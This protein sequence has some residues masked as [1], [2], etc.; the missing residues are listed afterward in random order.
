MTK[1]RLRIFWMLLFFSGIPLASFAQDDYTIEIVSGANPITGTGT[2]ISAPDIY[3][4]LPIGFTFE[5]FNQNYDHFYLS[6]NG[7]ITFNDDGDEGCCSSSELPGIN[8]PNNLIAFAWTYLDPNAGQINY[9]TTGSAPNRILVVN[10]NGVNQY[11]WWGGAGNPITVQL[12]LYEGSNTIE[13]HV[14]S[15]PAA[16]YDNRTMGIENVDGTKAYVVDGRNANMN[17]VASDEVVRFLPYVPQPNDAGIVEIAEVSPACGSAPVEVTLQNFG[18]NT[19]STVEIGWSVN[20]VVQNSIM[21]TGSPLV[22]YGVSGTN[23]ALVSLG[24]INVV[25][26]ETYDIQAWTISPNGTTDPNLANDTSQIT[27]Y[28]GL[29]GTYTI[30]QTGGDFG[31]WTEAVDKLSQ[32]GV[33]GPVVFDVLGSFTEQI[34]I[35]EITGASATNTITFQSAS[36][37]AIDAVLSAF[38][39]NFNTNYTL[40]LDGTDHLIVQNLTIK[41]NNSSF[42]RAIWMEG[43]T[44]HNQFIGNII[45][46]QGTNGAVIE[47]SAGNVTT[48]IAEFNTFKS[49]NIKNGSTGIELSG[50]STA[51]DGLGEQNLIEDNVFENQHS[52]GINLFQQSAPLVKGN[53]ITL[54]S[55]SSTNA[56]GIRFFKC[57]GA[58]QIINN[59]ISILNGGYGIIQTENQ[60]SLGAEGRVVNN[61]VLVDGTNQ[62]RGI[63]IS[64]V[65]YVNYYHNTFHVKSTNSNSVAFQLGNLWSVSS[66]NNLDLRNNI[67][68]NTGGGY[69]IHLN[70]SQN[71]ISISDYNVLY[72]TGDFIGYFE[73]PIADLASWQT[74]TQKEA[75][76]L[77]LN[78][79]FI[80]DTDLHPT[81]IALN[82]TGDA[83]GISEDLEGVVRGTPPDIGAYEFDPTG[84]DAK[85]SSLVSPAIPFAHGNQDVKVRLTNNGVTSLS[86]VQ[87][88][89][90]VNDVLQNPFSWS[91]SLSSGQHV[92][93]N[94]GAFS[95]TAGQ[96][97][98]IEVWTSAPNGGT[99]DIAA[100]DQIMEMGLYPM[101]ASGTYT[102]GLGQPYPTFQSAINAMM[103][104]GIEA[105]ITFNVVSGTY[106]EQLIIPEII[107]ANAANSIVFQ[108]QSGDRTDVI[109]QYGGQRSNTNYVVQLDGI[110]GV[111]FKNMTIKTN[112][113]SRGRVI[114]IKNEANHI[115]FENNELIGWAFRHE[116]VKT[117]AD[118]NDNVHF[119][120][121]RIVNGTHGVFISG[122]DNANPST[123]WVVMGNQFENQNSS[124][125]WGDYLANTSISENTF[126]G[127]SS[128]L[129]GIHLQRSASNI[130]I[131]KNIMNFT[132]ASFGINLSIVTDALVSNNMI[133]ISG[134]AQIRGIVVN[135]CN[136]SKIYYNSVRVASSNSFS[137]A[138]RL[139]YSSDVDI[140]NN[141]L[142]NMQVGYAIDVSQL[143]N[144]TL[145]FNNLYST[146]QHIAKLDH[147]DQTT[148]ADWRSNSL[149]D[150]NSLAVNPTFV[151]DTDLHS[152]AIELNGAGTP[153]TDVTDDIDG[154]TR[155]V[156]PDI[157]ADEFVPSGLDVAME[158]LLSPNLPF[159]PGAQ[160][161]KIRFKN[162]GGDAITRVTLNWKVNGAAQSQV[163][164]EDIANPINSGET[165]DLVLGNYNFTDGIAYEVQAWLS[166]PNNSTDLKADNDTLT[167]SSLYTRMAGSYT[168]GGTD[169]NFTHIQAAVDAL[170]IGGV[171]GEVTFNIRSDNYNEQVRI[172][173]IAGA[174]DQNRI[175]FQSETRNRDDVILLYNSIDFSKNYILQLH[176]ADYITFRDVTIK[177]LGSTRSRVL[178]FKD[179]AN[180]NVF[181]NTVL[182]GR[183]NASS[184]DAR[185]VVYSASNLLPDEYNTFSNNKIVN[186]SN[187]IHWQGSSSSSHWET[188]NR[189][190]NNQFENQ[191]QIGIRLQYQDSCEII[192]NTIFST[193]GITAID[194]DNVYNAAKILGNG[195]SITNGTGIDLS[196]CDGTAT[197]PI[198]MANNMISV[199]NVNNQRHGINIS[200]G[201]YVH[202][203]HNTVNVTS[204]SDV[205][206]T[207]LRLDNIGQGYESKNNIFAYTG[208]GAQGYALYERNATNYTSSHNLLYS[209]SYLVDKNGTNYATLGEWQ[210]ASGQEANA[211]SVN[212][213]FVSDTDLHVSEVLL[214][215]TG[216]PL[217]SVTTDFDGETRNTTN[218]DIGADEFTPAAIDVSLELIQ[219]A[220][221]PFGEGA[222]DVVVRMKNA[223]SSDLS[224]V[225]FHWK[226]NDIPQS[227]FTWN[228]TLA[229]GDTSSITIGQVNFALKTAYNIEVWTSEA[230]DANALNDSLKAENLYAGLAGTYQIQGTNPDFDSF[231]EAVNILS[232]G[233]VVGQTTLRVADGIYNEQVS[234]PSLRGSSATN[235]VTF[236]SASG[237]N[238]AVE[239]RIGATSTANYTLQFNGAQY[240]TFKNMS[241]TALSN[242]NGRVIDFS[243]FNSHIQLEGNIL[244]GFNSNNNYSSM[245]VI[246]SSNGNL[247]YIKFI[248]NEIIDGDYGVFFNHNQP[249]L[250]NEFVG[251]TFVGQNYR[252]IE[253]HNQDSIKIERNTISALGS[254]N[255]YYGIY[256]SGSRNA[257][258]IQKN[259]LTLNSNGIGIYMNAINGT[260]SNP[261]TIA[262]NMVSLSGTAGH[263]TYGIRFNNCD[264]LNVYH[265]TAHVYGY[266]AESPNQSAALKFKSIYNS[267]I[268]NN[269]SSNTTGGYAVY[270]SN[271]GSNDVFNH[272]NYYTTGT[273]FVYFNGVEQ[274]NLEAWKLSY[275]LLNANSYNVDPLFISDVDLHI[276][277]VTLQAGGTATPIT[278]DIDDEIRNTTTPSIGA[279]EFP[280]PAIDASISGLFQPVMPFASGSQEVMVTI[281]NQGANVLTSAQLN[282]SVN[283]TTQSAASWT[284]GNVATGD[285]TTVNIGNYTFEPFTVYEVKVWTSN[286]NNGT[287]GN[288]NND[289]LTVSG[290]YVGLSGEYTIGG[291]AP[292]FSTTQEAINALQDGG[293][294]GPVVFKLRDGSYGEQVAIPAILGA[295][296]T[297][298]ISFESESGISANVIWEYSAS[299]TSNYT[300]NL[301]G[302]EYFTFK[303]LTFKALN[304]AQ[305]CV[306]ALTNGASNNRFEG[307]II[308]GIATTGIGKGQ[309]VIYSESE[310][311]S[312]NNNEFK[313]NTIRN[314]SY[315]F[316]YEGQSSSS[317]FD[318]G[319]RL[320]GNVFENQYYRAVYLEHQN[321]PQ[322]IGNHVT[323]NSA[324]W[325]FRGLLL[326]DC[327]NEV[328][329]LANNI[330][331]INGGTAINVKSQGTSGSLSALVAN[332]FTSVGGTATTAI[333]LKLESNS[334][335]EVYYNTSHITNTN[336]SN[337]VAAVYLNN[338][339][340]TKFKNNSMVNSGGGYAM[341]VLNPNT[342][343]LDYNNHY[344]TGVNLGYYNSGNRTDLAAW[345]SVTGQEANSLSVDPNFVSDTDLHFQEIALDG[346]GTPIAAVTDDID[347]EIRN[348][349]HPDMG[350]DEF[351]PSSVDITVSQLVNPSIPFTAQLQE[352]KLVL[353][354]SGLD[355]IT[356]VQLNW[357]VNNQL[358]QA[359]DWVG[360]LPSAGTQEVSLGYFTFLENTEYT[361]K[362][363]AS[364]PNN[365]TG[366]NLEDD[367]LQVSNLQT[368]L[369][370]IYTTGSG[371]NFLDFNDAVNALEARGVS[372]PTTF[373][374]KSA[375]YT[376]QVSIASIAGTS[377][378]NTII[379][380]SE[381]GVNTDVILEY[382]HTN[383]ANYVLRLDGADYL[384]FK[385]M[386]IQASGDYTSST[387]T[388][389]VVDIRN[390]ATNNQFV[391]NRLIG[392]STLNVSRHGSTEVAVVYSPEDATTNA[393]S[394]KN[395]TIQNGAYGIYSAGL[396]VSNPSTG[397][398]IDGNIISGQTK[399][400]VELAHQSGAIVS[401]NEFTSNLG[402]DYIGIKVLG[403][404]GAIQ[405]TRNRIDAHSGYYALYIDG[406]NA[407]AQSR[408]LIANNFIFNDHSSAVEGLRL[409]DMSYTDIY[410]NT[411]RMTGGNSSSRA[412]SIFS[413]NN[414]KFI[415]NIATH[416]ADG[417]SIYASNA[418]NGFIADH[419]LY[420]STSPTRFAYYN[421]S[422]QPQVQDWQSATL[423]DF[424][425]NVVDPV[426]TSASGF[427]VESSL[428]NGKAIPLPA[429][430]EDIDRDL[431]SSTSPD[432]GADEFS[433]STTDAGISAFVSPTIPLNL[434]ANNLKVALTNYG[435][436]TLTKATI[437]WQ[438]D[439]NVQA[440][441]PWE[442]SLSPGASE[443]IT[444]GIYDFTQPYNNYTI[445]AWAT[446]PNDLV[447]QNTVNDTLS[448]IGSLGLAGTYSIGGVNPDFETF[449]GAIDTLTLFGARGPVTFSVADGTYNEQLILD[450]IKGVSEV[451]TVSF[452]SA[453][454]IREQVVLSFDA[455]ST[456]N[457]TVLL[458]G[459]KHITFKQMTIKALNTT[460]AKVISLVSSDQ[461]TFE[462]N[463]IEGQVNNVSI[464]N[465][466]VVSTDNATT[467]LVFKD[468]L[469]KNG[470]YGLYLDGQ[471]SSD[472]KGL[473]IEGNTFERQ[474]QSGIYLNEQESP[475]IRGNHISSPNTVSSYRAIWLEECSE[476][477]EISNNKIDVTTASYG[478]ELKKCN[479]TSSNR[480]LIFNNFIHVGGTN[481]NAYGLWLNDQVHDQYIYH[482]SVYITG[483]HTSSA[484]L[485]M[486]T[487][488]SGITFMNNIF[489]N[490]AGGYALDV[491]NTAAIATANYNNLYSS[492][493]QLVGW[494]ATDYAALS[495]YQT[496]TAKGLN[497]VSINPSFASGSDLHISL[498]ALDGLGTP[499]QE[500][501]LD[502]DGQLRND[503]NPDM[504]ADEFGNGLSTNNIGVL[505]LSNHALGCEFS[506]ET[507]TVS[508]RNYGVDLISD[509]N[510]S[511]AINGGAPI[512]EQVTGFDLAGGTSKAYSFT[513]LADLSA[514]GDYSIQFFTELAGDTDLGND[515]LIAT[516]E[517]TAGP[518]TTLTTDNDD[519]CAR[520]TANLTASGGVSYR[521][522][523]V[524]NTALLG[525]GAEFAV[526]PDS[527]TA[528]Y[529]E[530]ADNN[531][532][533][534]LDTISLTVKNFPQPEI[535]SDNGF[536]LDCNT[537]TINLSSSVEENIIWSTSSALATI[538]V[539][540]PGTYKVTH[541]NQ[542]TGCESE[543]SVE[544]LADPRPNL[545]A[546]KTLICRGETVR[547][548]AENGISYTWE[549]YLATDSAIDVTPAE[550]TI[551]R[552]TISNANG[553]VYKD[554]IRIRIREDVRLTG[555][556][557]DTSICLGEEITLEASGIAE[558]FNWSNNEIGST[559]QVSP[560]QTTTYTVT[561]SDACNV[562]T[563]QG[564][565]TITVL[566]IPQLPVISPESAVIC[567]GN[568]V[569]L[570][571]SMTD[572][573]TWSTDESTASIT[574]N[575]AGIYKVFHEGTNGC[576]AVDS[577][578]VSFPEAPSIELSGY[579]TICNGQSI[580]LGVINGNTYNWTWTSGSS[581]D[582]SITVS[583]T[584]TT[585][586]YVDITNSQGCSY[587]DSM[588]IKVIEPF[589]PSTFGNL[590]PANGEDT[591]TL[592]L[593]FS[594][595]P[596]T[597][598]SHYDLYIW[599]STESEPTSATVTDLTDFTFK[600]HQL[601]YGSSYNW[602]VIAKNSCFETP[603][604][605]Q[606]FSIRQLPD[607][608]PV[609]VKAPLSAFSG[610]KIDVEMEIKNIGLGKTDDQKTWDDY[611]YLSPDKQL[612]E[613]VDFRLGGTNNLTALDANQSYR[614]TIKDLALPKGLDGEYYI[615]TKTNNSNRIAEA[616]L[617]NNVRRSN[618]PLLLNLT[619]P[620]DLK[621]TSIIHLTTAFSG[622]ELQVTWQVM[623]DG[624]GPTDGGNWQDKVYLSKD[625]ILRVGDAIA[626]GVF[627]HDGGKL[628]VGESYEQSQ[629]V[630]IPIEELG[631]YYVHVV[632]D[633]YD[634][635]YEHVYENNNARSGEKI[636]VILAPPADMIVTQVAS[637]QDVV[638]NLDKVAIYWTG[639]NQG[640]ADLRGRYWYDGIYL[641]TATDS[642]FLK[643]VLVRERV[644]PSGTYSKID[645]ITIP[646]DI[647]GVYQLGVHIDHRDLIFESIFTDNN[648]NFSATDLTVQSPDIHVVAV[649]TPSL[650]VDTASTAQTVTV[651][652]TVRNDGAGRLNGATDWTDRIFLS[653]VADPSE[654]FLETLIT[655]GSIRELGSIRYDSTINAG[656]S[657][658]M[659]LELTIPEDMVAGDYHVLVQLDHQ[660]DLYEFPNATNNILSKPLYVKESPV[661][662]LQIAN[663]L[664]TEPTDT[665][666]A[667]RRAVLNYDLSNLGE[668]TAYPSWNNAVYISAEATFNA[669]ARR[670]DLERFNDT[671]LVNETISDSSVM[672]LPTDLEAGSYY[673]FLFV[674]HDSSIYE[675]TGETNNV[676]MVRSFFVKPYPPADLTL[677]AL[678]AVSTANSGAEIQVDWEVKNIGDGSQ[679]EK[680]WYDTL[681][682]STDNVLDRGND[683]VIDYWEQLGPLGRGKSYDR[684]KLVEIPNGISGDYYLIMS[685]SNPKFQNAPLVD[686]DLSNNEMAV[687][688]HIDLT[689]YPDLLITEHQLPTQGIAGQPI[690][691]SWTVKNQGIDTA[692]AD[693]ID[694]LYLSTDL[695]IDQD[696]IQLQVHKRT[697]LL[698]V[699]SSYQVSME[700]ILPMLPTGNYILLLKTDAND[701]WYEHQAED[702]NVVNATIALEQPLPSDLS[703]TSISA[704]ATGLAGSEVT[705]QWT[706]RN[707]GTNVAKGYWTDHIYFSRD[708]KWDIDDVLVGELRSYKE[709]GPGTQK[710]EQLNV[711]LD[712]VSQGDYHVIVRADVKNYI[713]E[714]DELNNEFASVDP[715]NIAVNELK[716]GITREAVLIDKKNLYYRI[717]IPDSLA[718]ETLLVSLTG[719]LNAHNELYIKHNQIPTRSDY[720]DNFDE[721][722]TSNQEVLIASLKAG[723]YYLLV[724]GD[725]IEGEQQNVTLDASI[726]EFSIRSVETNKGGQGGQVTVMIE[727][728]KFTE[729]TE[730]KVYNSQYSILGT[731]NKYVDPTKVFVTFNLAG[732]SLGL[733]D[734]VAEQPNGTKAYMFGGFRVTLSTPEQIGVELDYPSAVRGGRGSRLVTIYV[735]YKNIGNVDV[736]LSDANRLLIG[737]NVPVASTP[738]GLRMKLRAVTLEFMEAQGPESL[739]RPG[740]SGTIIVYTTSSTL[741][742]GD[743]LK[744]FIMK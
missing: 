632:T 342:I 685:T 535:T 657:V 268:I 182:E 368:A 141:I 461:I 296:V 556:T 743:R 2:N 737:Q 114:D 546:S 307:N 663:A 493:P 181:H 195:I 718:G 77:S 691:V 143:G 162:T 418:I 502:I 225:A 45:E 217:A 82:G 185:A 698:E 390:G 173:A 526:N 501:S 690:Q 244:K 563:A 496:N 308:E 692:F 311:K 450:D 683:I 730:F 637:N 379:F 393:N 586:Y 435:E 231:T 39:N 589:A 384:V 42:P 51:V 441:V 549:G 582:S 324:H 568:S 394:F 126:N 293:V 447:D 371:G 88:N 628:A 565:I 76:A 306:I 111:T 382:D 10:F 117:T 443:T 653:Q 689:P 518:A 595:E 709:I 630:T 83:V 644:I 500:V 517:H 8:T 666:V 361:I 662:D 116:V 669:N 736:P 352:V 428:A 581:T 71:P 62:G 375:T 481:T 395:N 174:S 458:D 75:N 479:A 547:L 7:F 199:T 302:A 120:N 288:S 446:N 367:T 93:V 196:G 97:H 647:N 287:D 706:T 585:T 167:I 12:L 198:L 99:D 491:T 608:I 386:T 419:N 215:Q 247:S 204:T 528:Y 381:T 416:F 415:N 686:D 269:I 274:A 413:S 396:N 318:Q 151:S 220:I 626:L 171:N 235:T 297:N 414:I 611:V 146:G 321:A 59:E 41:A 233:G 579:S 78:P 495:D 28:G 529:V 260:A 724:Y 408:A 354:N 57:H 398:V 234:I 732:T 631:E 466:L 374:V 344:T 236:E 206:K 580:T 136:S 363:W 320:E 90:K 464:P 227:S 245:A 577:V 703:V 623:N 358:Q 385:N 536:Y 540:E 36:G 617:T 423:Q 370:G 359:V 444:L 133:S 251:N 508:V 266:T 3:A 79:I 702:N 380:E 153:L 557:A 259:K 365:E 670:I 201:Q 159:N 64:N 332:N 486:S 473:L 420:Y 615:L 391:G 191:S 422:D 392:A 281:K 594:W 483:A 338:N 688:L 448:I 445:M 178:E 265:N 353:K 406:L 305:S 103:Q 519:F 137:T 566:P 648:N 32:H 427:E 482:N 733:H 40:R 27:L 112:S 258:S 471:L 38:S 622:Q 463:V 425:S 597:N 613:D 514:K 291:T 675:R 520:E 208:L 31:S 599:K 601:A 478:I 180:H 301:D 94:I 712:G 176:E 383:A 142:S 239:L 624:D 606:Q 34:S 646:K 202:L 16:L 285:E 54:N 538:E 184:G 460:N 24:S 248:N 507:L 157:G 155:N 407:T 74:K 388:G 378:T 169:P 695:E 642:I 17:W 525:L 469:F 541:Y 270:A 222:Q 276:Q 434:G 72:S 15:I 530:V 148:L 454:G 498:P 572:N 708:T 462:D 123:G 576:K 129:S 219:N 400:G 240:I 620:P 187:G 283:G 189:F 437:Q 645:T 56:F 679:L 262:N 485:Y 105:P 649:E 693:W 192:G 194:L 510:I 87:I 687:P 273:K 163:V 506:Q 641:K 140:K 711:T 554:S 682:L 49:N 118:I 130:T 63:N 671:L 279:D 489:A 551:Y 26:G 175:I 421:N 263:A 290:I 60:A 439:G 705:V 715:I 643:E 717:E 633:V 534:T 243:N 665:L 591:L 357:E 654:S 43:R 455:T 84:L 409:D 149:Q 667:G 487:G 315:G 699:D 457:Y 389:I 609:E 106:T 681:Y 73:E 337:S 677:H 694:K 166:N 452:Q 635:E 600:Y 156:P 255:D 6:P 449:T 453:S 474:Y 295:S 168:I 722:F 33:C 327:D 614:Q 229:S 412:V 161:V 300:L 257:T 145:D 61:S 524:G 164:W 587:S 11:D 125:F 729:D 373:K 101:L 158:E 292:D 362:V 430:T 4:A 545:S 475:I 505:A 701:K 50:S 472:A 165:K 533:I 331:L 209:T 212:P 286:P 424:N 319:T 170:I 1:Y 403:G 697:T 224:N 104:G 431:R 19:L 46:G 223:G 625:S 108:S 115:R 634:S 569:Q 96:A 44:T 590:V 616:D 668:V 232:L 513:T 470:S 674:D 65:S 213:L 85:I 710:T 573:I 719:A 298:T 238:T 313:S 559:I 280:L 86:N 612:E 193:A 340:N 376:E 672:F 242:T 531:G 661:A 47:A 707:N 516:I 655:N 91:G 309:A 588:E 303:N 102:I 404:Q 638:S 37:N 521:W 218:P 329:V 366:I 640:A 237:N 558:T 659:Q 228:N 92:E 438:V 465:A 294:V 543:A 177:A 254:R 488:G 721:P 704:P 602:K 25:A 250:G 523:E 658:E 183:P 197:S 509:F 426:F 203:Y 575:D 95:F 497:S 578:E 503:T 98:N 5:F 186:G 69:A 205:L 253:V 241:I 299:S 512:T 618:K 650:Q 128:S 216:T 399:Y 246:H 48:A 539:T 610:Q 515:T 326:D 226:V 713:P 348:A 252:G 605:T 341:Y 402:T 18:E 660:D 335:I 417:Y 429:I 350:A 135:S 684:S 256:L 564:E 214:N 696:D 440:T 553:C 267:H 282:W 328:K 360:S 700:A 629:S 410:H 436:E 364:N 584:V 741:T 113:S 131:S 58:I 727:G 121:N 22:G 636:T 325:D 511:Y 716:I 405:I 607:L 673:F 132:I 728:A 527:T 480:G 476:N 67:F 397:L 30:Q 188:G 433:L 731:I 492:G 456:P 277:E 676:L 548:T 499:T 484:A 459:A 210:V 154:T 66:G 477:I 442:G 80:A 651:T 574:V 179:G 735:Q 20:G 310:N 152:S 264:Y 387:A 552:V 211:Q 70:N 261:V 656:D 323:T 726:I 272:N 596:A 504:G 134:T 35:G 345:K 522:Y 21:Y 570:T 542:V 621:V 68:V 349:I 593:T 317:S 714:V 89:W 346:K 619:P 333:G 110:D 738:E 275:P 734:I 571:S 124:A 144:N 537:D 739:L 230:S 249:T 127:G 289:T 583:P 561:L 744:F 639:K 652:W 490:G 372:G 432:I 107:G 343:E 190:L 81:D 139:E 494:G 555:I 562:T 550:T 14:T 330:S 109:L 336:S 742:T 304:T 339:T 150:A 322:V 369:S 451:N 664:F 411:I 351:T 678:T 604:V 284:N 316:Y 532:C 314:G 720:D 355:E 334:H 55:S 29:S 200:H 740:A 122:I 627:A 119:V 221:I 347:G 271:V 592:P 172:P 377:E 52:Y 13:I 9:F 207:A 278:D 603:S 680:V 356:G 53:K 23:S 567:E 401:G 544:V 725:N 100:N 598:A 723:T 312:K 468:N 147:V 160:E 138:L 560:T 467:A